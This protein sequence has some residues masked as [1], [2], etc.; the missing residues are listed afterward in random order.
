MTQFFSTEKQ[1]N[2]L[3]SK[4][5]RS[6]KEGDD[7][8]EPSCTEVERIIPDLCL[9]ELCSICSLPQEF[10]VSSS[11]FFPSLIKLRL[12]VFLHTAFFKKIHTF[13]FFVPLESLQS[14]NVTKHEFPT[15]SLEN[16]QG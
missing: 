3:R 11:S 14:T 10:Y 8:V 5:T 1:S 9:T 4:E 6:G 7:P 13:F 12:S 16:V 2:E 15:F